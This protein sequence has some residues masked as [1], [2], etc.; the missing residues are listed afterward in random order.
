MTF[1]GFN[2][3]QGWHTVGQ[4]IAHKGDLFLPDPVRR[5]IL[6]GMTNADPCRA[7]IL[8]G[9]DTLTLIGSPTL[10]LSGYQ[11][12]QVPRLKAL[13]ILGAVLGLCECALSV[14]LLLLEF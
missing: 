9:L 13:A 12:S 11:S 7:P 2:A 6:T 4:R 1:R 8:T 10:T 5:S 14:E 3:L